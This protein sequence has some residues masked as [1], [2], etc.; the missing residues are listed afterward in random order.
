MTLVGEG[1]RRQARITVLLATLSCVCVAAGGHAT[2]IDAGRGARTTS[3]IDISGNVSPAL[4]Q[5]LDR[6]YA[7]LKNGQAPAAVAELRKAIELAPNDPREL[8]RYAVAQNA[9]GDRGGA[10]T[11]LQKAL[12]MAPGFNDGDQA[13]ALLA[14]LSR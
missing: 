5:V 13:K 11:S 6:T 12:S 3:A 8:Y 1:A 7:L 14:E 9:A 4:K 10:R 2:P